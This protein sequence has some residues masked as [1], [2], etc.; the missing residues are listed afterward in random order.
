MIKIKPNP[1]C[2][3]CYDEHGKAIG[4]WQQKGGGWVACPDCG[5]GMCYGCKHATI[6]R[7]GVIRCD[8]H[9]IKNPEDVCDGWER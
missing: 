3:S 4:L 5:V 9:G 7:P 1:M 2:A 8:V 6:M